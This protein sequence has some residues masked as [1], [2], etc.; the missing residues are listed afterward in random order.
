MK[1]VFGKAEKSMAKVA[2]LLESVKGWEELELSAEES[3][4]LCELASHCESFLS[5]FRKFEEQ[6]E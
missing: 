4:A 5:Q 3:S 6:C 2:E 1:Q